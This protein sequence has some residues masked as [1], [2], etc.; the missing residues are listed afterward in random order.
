MSKSLGILVSSNI[1][2]YSADEII[3]GTWFGKDLYRRCFYVSGT[4]TFSQSTADS[5]N[6]KL[7]YSYADNINEIDCICNVKMIATYLNSSG[8]GYFDLLNYHEYFLSDN[9][10]ATISHWCT[11]KA[12]GKFSTELIYSN[13]LTS[14]AFSK[15]Y[16][17][18]EYTK[19]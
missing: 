11:K 16:T 9:K 15:I 10:V 17:I 14:R 3:V 1:S 19:K 13:F 6:S 5:V 2:T 12:S 18:I 8:Y 7:I 4:E